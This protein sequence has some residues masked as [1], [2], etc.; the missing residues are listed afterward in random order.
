MKIVVCSN[1]SPHLEHIDGK[2]DC[3]LV[4]GLCPIFDAKLVTWNI[5]NDVDWIEEKLN[6]W[7]KQIDAPTKVVTGSPSD[8][9]AEFY[10]SQ[11]SFYVAGEYIQDETISVKGLNIY[12]MPWTP[13]LNQ[14]REL[15]EAFVAKNS[16]FLSI[17]IDSIPDDTD[18]LICNMHAHE[19]AEIVMPN[20]IGDVR[21]RKRLESL[22]KLK[23]F[24]H[25]NKSCTPIIKEPKKYLTICAN[26]E[27]IG[28]STV[29]NM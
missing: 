10:G 22:R 25:G 1:P 21:L 2:F 27:S 28:T 11:L 24:V 18:I 15:T 3:A 9:V 6:P 26:Q 20:L 29:V 12:S 14:N 13:G 23:L 16:E 7:L 8:Y 4:C 19:C 5:V 17:A